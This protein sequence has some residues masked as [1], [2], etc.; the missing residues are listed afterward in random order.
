MN[1]LPNDVQQA[2][3]ELQT[4]IIGILLEQARLYQD[5]ARKMYS[6]DDITNAE[7]YNSKVDALLDTIDIVRSVSPRSRQ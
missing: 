7:L 3:N 5:E 4:K 2:Q 6:K 1:E